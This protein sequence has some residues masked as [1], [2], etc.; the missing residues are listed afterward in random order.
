MGKEMRMEENTKSRTNDM[1][2]RDRIPAL[3][4]MSFGPGMGLDMWGLWLYP[5]VAFAVFHI[6]LG[7]DPWLAG[8]ALTMIRI[9]D[10]IAQTPW[11]AGYQIIFVRGTGGWGKNFIQPV[12]LYVELT[13]SPIEN[14]L[15]KI[16]LVHL[17]IEYQKSTYYAEPDHPLHDT[18]F[19][20]LSVR[21]KTL[22]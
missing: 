20:G 15:L 17:D 10:A 13:Q 5:A 3:T 2:K 19:K 12:R 18:Q 21:L 11:S 4:K 8:L 14:E 9:Y 16:L 7:V 1:V 22:L 6:Y